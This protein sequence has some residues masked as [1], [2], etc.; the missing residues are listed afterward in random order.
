MKRSNGRET[1]VPNYIDLGQ[2]QQSSVV[3]FPGL[4][5][6]AELDEV[7]ACHRN[8][9]ALGDPLE[10][11]T[12]NCEH[13]HKVCTFLHGPRVPSNGQLIQH[14]PRILAKLLRAAV[15]AKER[16]SWASPSATASAV[17][18]PEE[19]ETP[20]AT[21]S[22][23]SGPLGNIDVRCLSIRVVEFWEYE[24]GGGLVDDHHYDAGSIITV[25][26][27]VSDSSDCAGGIFRTFETDGHHAEHH[28]QRGDVVC[29]LSH[30]YHNVTPISY[31]HR[32]SLVMELWQ[33]GLPMWCR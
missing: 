33:G 16:G 4:L 19:P 26:C 1:V 32:L 28:M 22:P 7:L 18:A 5:G 3:H 10:M 25:V 13:K 14:C 29:L 30:K 2:A 21:D 23:C 27:Q 8:A 15:Q 9:A 24:K 20:P 17:D 12:Q 6:A 11:N 31:G